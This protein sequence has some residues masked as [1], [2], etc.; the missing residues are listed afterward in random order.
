M[1]QE[2]AQQTRSVTAAVQARDLKE[3]NRIIDHAKLTRHEFNTACDRLGLSVNGATATAITSEDGE[4]PAAASAPVPGPWAPQAPQT[5][6][7]NNA[8]LG[9]VETPV[10]FPDASKN[11]SMDPTASKRASLGGSVGPLVFYLDAEGRG[12]TTAL[13]L[14]TVEND[15]E[16]V[17]RLLKEV[18]ARCC[19]TS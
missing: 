6:G 17:R 8:R 4:N 15:A 10:V 12:G 5:F 7:K 9:G 1:V 11:T 16:T 13:A 2:N 19:R 18:G 3:I 14:A